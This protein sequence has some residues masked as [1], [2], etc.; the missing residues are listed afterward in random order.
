MPTQTETTQRLRRLANRAHVHADR[1]FGRYEPCGEHHMHDD[2][3][4]ARPCVCGIAE[5][6]DLR[7]LLAEY[8]RILPVY[9][10]A[11]AAGIAGVGTDDTNINRIFDALHVAITK[12]RLESGGH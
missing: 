11:R 7:W 1:C 10:A 3:C 2:T 8:T 12:V 5:D 9:E 4:G 6:A